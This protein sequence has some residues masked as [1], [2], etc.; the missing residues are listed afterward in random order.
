VQVQVAIPESGNLRCLSRQSQPGI[1]AGEAKCVVLFPKRRIK[2]GRIFLSQQIEQIASMNLVTFAAVIYCNRPVKG[3][4]V[5]DHFAHVTD[6]AFGGGY[7]LVMAF[8]AYRPRI[9]PEQPCVLCGV[10]IVTVQALPHLRK[11]SVLD[12]RVLHG[13]TDFIVAGKTQVFHRLPQQLGL[14]GG[15]DAVTFQAALS[16]GFV[17]RF[18]ARQAVGKNHMAVQAQFS[19]LLTQQLR[20]AGVVRRMTAQASPFSDRLVLHFPSNGFCMT[21]LAQSRN[22][23]RAQAFACLAAMRIVTLRASLLLQGLVDK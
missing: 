19:R 7:F 2:P 15:V 20:L 17:N 14:A 9:V 23:I 8:Q 11:G 1:V 3:L 6:F 12:F 4:F 16:H 21:L 22:R 18:C 13:Q 5:C 10:G